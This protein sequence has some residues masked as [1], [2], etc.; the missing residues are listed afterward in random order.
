MNY[1]LTLAISFLFA[2]A[3][4]P[5]VRYI[6]IRYRF[7]DQPTK[8]K[9]HETPIPLM[10]GV[11]IYIG[12][13]MT[14]WIMRGWDSLTITIL[15]GGTMLVITGLVDDGYKAHHREFPVWPRLIIYLVTATVPLWFHIDI[16]GIRDLNHG[17]LMFP[18]WFAW[19]ATT[20]WVFAM[21]NMM[22]FIDGADGLAAGVAMI[23]S[24][25][26][27]VVALIKGDTATALSTIALCGVSG[28]FLL[29]NFHPAKI[30]MGDAGATFLGY[31]LAVIAISGSM[32]S[33][34][35]VTL[36]IPML[37]LGFPILDTVIVFSRRIKEG[38]GLH[39]AD[40]LHLHHVLMRWGLTQPQVVAFIYLVTILFG[41]LSLV[42]RL[43]LP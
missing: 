42:V 35:L 34:T 1:I 19:L 39:R 30:F 17:M 25:T 15:L 28:G 14:L 21:T 10:G 27:F 40:K 13:I 33:T 8:R 2:S 18:D 36:L 3:L 32:K 38:K 9:I 24:L 5:L 41:L 37:A 7:V 6:A 23:S 22:N 29:F 43:A 4:V 16:Q 31:T 11:A 26:L 12:F 20:I